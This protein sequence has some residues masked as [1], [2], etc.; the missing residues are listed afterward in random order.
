MAEETGTLWE[1]FS[2]PSSKDHGFA[3]IIAK[4]AVYAV[5]GI[6]DLDYANKKL[7]V[8]DPLKISASVVLPCEN[9]EKITIVNDN[10]AVGISVPDGYE[11]IRGGKI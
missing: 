8:C 4:Y 1:L 6:V 10:A 5:L 2:G 3:A 7:T 11:I 9:G